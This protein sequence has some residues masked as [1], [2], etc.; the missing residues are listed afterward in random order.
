MLSNPQQCMQNQGCLNTALKL[1]GKDASLLASSGLAQAVAQK[2][3]ALPIDQMV[4]SL[5]HGGDAGAMLQSAMGGAGGAFGSNVAQLAKATQADASKLHIGE[6]LGGPS[7]VMAAGGAAKPAQAQS[8]N[9]FSLG[10]DT[11]V[12]AGGNHTYGKSTQGDAG[13][14]CDQS[15]I[16]HSKC[17]GNPSIFQIV[18]DKISRTRDRVD[19]TGWTSPVNRALSGQ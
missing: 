4:D 9:P 13:P 7:T 18:S 17:Q 6:T 2:A 14:P 15:D 19:Q 1:G 11:N 3:A 16:W 5:Q 10:A 12:A 8:Q